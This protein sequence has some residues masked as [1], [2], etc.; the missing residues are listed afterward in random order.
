VVAVA[1]LGYMFTHQASAPDVELMPG[2][3]LAPSQVPAVVAALADANLK[4]CQVRGAKIYVPQ[5]RVTEYVAALAHSKAMPSPLGN[6]QREALSAG[7]PWDIGSQ[8]DRQRLMIAKQD[9]L[10]NAICLMPGIES[11]SVLFDESKPGGLQE[12]VLTVLVTVKPTGTGELDEKTV[13]AIRKMMPAAFAGL[14]LENVTVADL[15]GRTWCGTD[16][17]RAETSAEIQNHVA[18]LL[19]ATEGA[20]KAAE[21]TLPSFGQNVLNWAIR[22]RGTLTMIGLALVSVLA[23]RSMLRAGRPD[24]PQATAATGD[25][26]DAIQDEHNRHAEQPDAPQPRRLH[27]SGPSPSEEL[28]AIVADDPETAANVLRSWIG[29]GV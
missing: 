9:E 25:A 5:G 22:S 21:P 8:R 3:S 26:D 19:P 17:V 18:P 10:H 27:A 4:D 29:Q 28:S 20:T 11:A 12:K 24:E 15:N 16:Q 1:G 13:S 6:A 14:K 2:V 7:S 23:L